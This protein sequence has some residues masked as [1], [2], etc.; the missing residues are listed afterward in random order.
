MNKMKNTMKIK[1]CVYL[2]MIVLL[3]F[4]YS[5]R[6]DNSIINSSSTINVPVVTTNAVTAIT[7][8]SSVGGGD[9]TSDGGAPITARGVCWG[10]N[11]NPTIDSSK[12]TDGHGTGSFISN[13]TDLIANTTYYLRAYATN[14]VGIGYGNVISF[15]TVDSTV[16]DID[17]NVYHT[18]TIGTQVW[19]VENLRTTKNNDGTAIPNVTE[20]SGWAALSTPAFCWYNDDEARYKNVYGALYNWYAVNTGKLCPKGWHVPVDAEW[21][22]LVNFL[23]G[24][25]LSGGK[26]KET[27]TTHWS[28]PNTGADNSSGFSALPGG[29]RDDA[30][31]FWVVGRYGYWWSATKVNATSAWYWYLGYSDSRVTRRNDDNGEVYGF[32]VRCIK[33]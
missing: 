13:I 5:C 9:V 33:D 26:L 2:L 4:S 14:K 16:N 11:Q 21:T 28:S 23:G 10:T 8:T 25:S 3:I 27:R 18:L 7:N 32:S 29:C 22:T 17:G 31:L 1:N 24:D 30:G 15:T 12:T 6:K 20:A 19:M